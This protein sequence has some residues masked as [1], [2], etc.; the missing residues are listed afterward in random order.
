[1]K[2][3]GLLFQ[4]LLVAIVVKV[5][6]MTPYR[7]E[8]LTFFSEDKRTQI[9][10]PREGDTTLAKN[11]NYSV[12]WPDLGEFKH[13]NKVIFFTEIKRVVFLGG[14][15]DPGSD[16]GVIGVFDETGKLLKKFNAKDVIAN[17]EKL[18]EEFSQ[19][20]PNFPWIAGVETKNEMLNIDV[21][22]KKL[23]SLNVKE[24][25]LTEKNYKDIAE[26]KLG[27]SINPETFFQDNPE[28]E[29]EVV[30]GG[31]WQSIKNLF[32]GQ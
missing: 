32:K 25:L 1:M 29:E 12:T 16:L 23:L 11:R 20:M 30:E 24:L 31:F 22:N 27:N 13:P 14:L 19:M 17:L 4:V 15:G 28:K 8:V 6:A 3:K 7:P 2:Y 21:C 9:N 10:I 5:I 18:S 26:S